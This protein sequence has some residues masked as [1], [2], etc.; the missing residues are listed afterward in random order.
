MVKVLTTSEEYIEAGKYAEALQILQDGASYEHWIAKFG[1]QIRTGIA[2]CQLLKDQDT[3]AARETLSPMTE[4]EV[5]SIPEDSYWAQL[6]FKVDDE[7]QRLEQLAQPDEVEGALRKALEA[8]PSKLET[9]YELA[10]LLIEK[11]RSEE[12]IPLLL[13][14]LS[15]DRNWE[16]KKANEKLMDVF[17]K[18][19]QT[20][21]AV[22]KGRKRLANIMF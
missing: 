15:I 6:I 11:N 3:V 20:N 13:D 22:K 12:A 16:D 8:D 10:E 7:I 21:E 2:Y 1:A 18:L 17:K 4:A 5:A 19:G 9:Y 14:I